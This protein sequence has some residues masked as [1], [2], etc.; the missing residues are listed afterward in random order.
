MSQDLQLVK[1]Q[2]ET[3]RVGAGSMQLQLAVQGELQTI[4]GT[5]SGTMLEGTQHPKKFS[6]RITG[7]THATG[8]GTQILVGA[9]QG[10]VIV[11][12]EGGG[13]SAYL[14]PLSAQFSVDANWNGTGE[15]RIADQSYE[16]RVTRIRAL[17]MAD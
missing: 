17:E 2:F 11:T 3:G 16:C 5:A 7:V 12:T 4:D 15:F 14:A 13:A 6:G 1:L 8:L 9:L 10:Q